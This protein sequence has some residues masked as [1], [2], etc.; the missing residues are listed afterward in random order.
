M[1]RLSWCVRRVRARAAALERSLAPYGAVRGSQRGTDC[2]RGCS[3][4]PRPRLGT[5]GGRASPTARARGPSS[6]MGGAHALVLG[7]V[8]LDR[9]L[10]LVCPLHGGH[11]HYNA[12]EVLAA[13]GKL[14]CVAHVDRALRRRTPRDHV[15]GHGRILARPSDLRYAPSGARSISNSFAAG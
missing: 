15:L 5:A 4:P 6:R 7:R 8:H 1:A 3:R 14:I 13:F 2:A 10:A 11:G 9:D 12:D